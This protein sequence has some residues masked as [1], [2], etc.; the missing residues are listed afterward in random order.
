MIT[1][2]KIIILLILFFTMPYP[3]AYSQKKMDSWSGKYRQDTGLYNLIIN[4][5]V[6]DMLEVSFVKIKNRKRLVTANFLANVKGDLANMM[7]IH[8]DPDCRVELR[9]TRNG[10]KIS[11]FCG[12]PGDDIGLYRKIER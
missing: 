2:K 9:K 3:F 12:G 4:Q 8:D 6:T 5:V 1:S 10:I 7:S 11:D